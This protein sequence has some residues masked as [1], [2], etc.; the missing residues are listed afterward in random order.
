MLTNTGIEKTLPMDGYINILQDHY[1][2]FRSDQ[3]SGFYPTM[4]NPPY[5]VCYK[6]RLGLTP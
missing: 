1:T 6:G 5:I 4:N 2:V 3:C